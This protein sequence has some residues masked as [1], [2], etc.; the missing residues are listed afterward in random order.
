MVPVI[1]IGDY[2]YLGKR[3]DIDQNGYFEQILLDKNCY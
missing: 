1:L 2:F 3:V